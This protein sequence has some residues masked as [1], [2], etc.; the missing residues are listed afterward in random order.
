M[1][2]NNFMSSVASPLNTFELIFFNKLC[3]FNNFDPINTF[4]LFLFEQYS[5]CA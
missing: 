1:L 3:F 2:V 4:H 5:I